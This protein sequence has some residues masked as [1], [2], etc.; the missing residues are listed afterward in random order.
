VPNVA[1]TGASRGPS[2]EGRRG[3]R[4][5]PLATN[6]DAYLGI[7]RRV[8]RRSQRILL[9]PIRNDAC[10]SFERLS[11]CAAEIWPPPRR[12]RKRQ[13]H[14]HHPY[15]PLLRTVPGIG[16]VLAFTIAAEI[17]TIERFPHP[18]S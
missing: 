2:H 17:G 10:R 15:I 14:A 7:A 1:I 13:S 18:R 12:T 9:K 4:V 8:A 3:N 5:G 6:S 11:G 16:W